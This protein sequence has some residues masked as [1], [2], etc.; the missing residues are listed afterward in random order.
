MKEKF[1]VCY[2]R[3]GEMYR[4][5][6]TSKYGNPV[7]TPVNSQL[8]MLMNSQLVHNPLLKRQKAGVQ[9]SYCEV[10]FN[11]QKKGSVFDVDICCPANDEREDYVPVVIP[12]EVLMYNKCV[13]TS[14]T[15]QI[16]MNGARR[17]R[18]IIEQEFW[19][20]LWGFMYDCR[21]YANAHSEKVTKESIISDFMIMHGIP[22]SL[23]ENLIRYEKRKR[24]ASVND[25]EKRRETM[26][27]QTG[28]LFM[29][30]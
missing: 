2:I 10:A 9:D 27:Q 8:T 14:N 23:Y 4:A 11:Y 5:Y 1:N 16:S 3:I 18:S 12:A 21:A 25:I 24:T 17:F 30:T 20:D 6:V 7:I 15:W 29:Y 22:M 28:R 19:S 26:E 13:A